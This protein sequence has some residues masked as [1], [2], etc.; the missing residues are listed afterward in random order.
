MQKVYQWK[1]Y[2]VLR[3]MRDYFVESD[4][5]KLLAPRQQG[6]SNMPKQESCLGD[7]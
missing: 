7:I 1:R 5:V 3:E 2:K 4:Y 6:K